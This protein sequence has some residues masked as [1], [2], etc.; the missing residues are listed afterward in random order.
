MELRS[1]LCRVSLLAACAFMQTGCAVMFAREEMPDLRMVSV[2]ASREAVEAQL[3]EPISETRS[4]I[5]Q[6]GGK[7][8]VYKV[9]VRAQAPTETS[10]AETVADKFVGFDTLQF[11]VIY[12]R[13][14][15]V[16]QLQQS[17]RI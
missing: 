17:P 15:R 13:G 9:L 7:K 3:G 11:L 16:M 1:T 4:D 10:T 8:C 12:D 5:G 2:G 14:N 6:P